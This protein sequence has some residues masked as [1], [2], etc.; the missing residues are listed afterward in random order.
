[1]EDQLKIAVCEDTPEDV[2]KII[3]VIEKNPIPTQCTVF[4]SGEELLKVFHP[5]KYEL[6]LMDIYV[7][8]MTGVEVVQ[9]IR[10][11]DR[12][13]PIAFVTTSTEFTLESYRLSALKYIEKPFRK[14]EIDEILELAWMKHR[15]APSLTVR[16]NRKEIRIPLSKIVYIEQ[17]ARQL[18][19]HMQDGSTEEVYDKLSEYLEELEE[20]DFFDCHKSYAVNLEFVRAIDQEFRCFVMKNNENVPI[21]RESMSKAK[22]ALG[23]FLYTMTRKKGI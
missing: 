19:I 17:K 23:E 10:E 3:E 14:S 22:K 16:K 11:V 1:M 7:G 13:L 2:R 8:K 12:D 4:K 9:K 6:L 5:H 15:N 20:H 18:L 21:R